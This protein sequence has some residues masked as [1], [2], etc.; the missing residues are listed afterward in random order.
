[1]IEKMIPEGSSTDPRR[2]D[3]IKNVG[4]LCKRQGQFQLAC[5]LFTKSGEKLKAFKC[6]I[7]LG[8]VDKIVYY[9]N[10]AK[11]QQIFILAAN[12]LQNTDWHND[13]E[14]MKNIINF[15]TRAKAF[16]S[17]ANFYDS[18][19]VVEID[20][21][22]DYEKALGALQDGLKYLAKSTS[23]T[24]DMVYRNISTKIKYIE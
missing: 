19:A 7:K 9:A 2:I 4:R 23:Q 5:K 21:Y 12:Y 15:Y 17:L 20:D 22:R 24:K 10:V 14:L 8:E 18:V 3:L 11:N 1:M 13:A 16:D 6:L